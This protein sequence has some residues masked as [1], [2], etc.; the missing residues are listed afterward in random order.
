MSNMPSA[1]G[2]MPPPQMSMQAPRSA[3]MDLNRAWADMQDKSHPLSPP[4]QLLTHPAQPSSAWSAEFGSA[5][6]AHTSPAM[7]Q[8]Q[9]QAQGFAPQ[10]YLAPLYGGGM[11]QRMMYNHANFAPAPVQ[12][13]DK[14]KGK[15]REIDF[16][17]AFAALEQSL[18]PS[19]QEMA[20]IEELDDTADLAEAMERVNLREGQAEERSRD[21]TDF[22]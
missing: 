10:T 3:P 2:H 20:R 11:G 16:D 6:Q 15:G 1:L 12:A 21:E 9:P 7:A 4:H 14:G 8:G 17:A 22:N 19:A 5:A 13:A 18:G